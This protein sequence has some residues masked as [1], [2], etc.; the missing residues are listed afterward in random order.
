MKIRT[1][2]V[3]DEKP[4]REELKFLLEQF[5]NIEI[6]GIAEHA[7][8]GLELILEKRPD[9]AFIDIE[10]PVMNGLELAEKLYKMKDL[11]HPKI[12][13]TTT[14]DKFVL[15]AFEVEAV[16]YLLKPIL[17]ERLKA[18]MDRLIPKAKSA[19][20]S[21]YVQNFSHQKMKKVPVDYKGRYKMI[22]LEDILFFFT[23]EGDI[24]AK[25]IEGSYTVNSNLT[26]LEENL[27]DQVFFRCHRSFL[28]NLNR[29]TEVVPWFKGKYLL[30]MDDKIKSEV[31]V[32][33][34][35]IKELCE[36]LKI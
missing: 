13:F 22:S 20:Q 12:V 5:S 9:I 17:D 30:I 6:V 26:E 28:V 29:V 36:I 25:T 31:Y 7:Q 19:I 11:I 32:S 1:V 23:E 27:K 35:Y 14:Y 8:K 21:E 10:M 24:V 16:D 18:T 33:R 4:A 15:N 3:E 34:T 2:I